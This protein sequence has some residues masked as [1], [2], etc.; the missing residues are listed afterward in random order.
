MPVVKTV[1]SCGAW[2]AGDGR[3]GQPLGVDCAG[4]RVTLPCL[5]V[6]LGRVDFCLAVGFALL[7]FV[8][9]DD[10]RAHVDRFQVPK[11]HGVYSRRRIRLSWQPESL[12]LSVCKWF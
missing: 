1:G 2:G 11:V 6:G 5:G 4:T 12:S 10:I 7:C 8:L 3:A 9:G